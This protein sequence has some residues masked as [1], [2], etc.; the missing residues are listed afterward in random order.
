MGM[1]FIR[2]AIGTVVPREHS[3]IIHEVLNDGDEHIIAGG[4][5]VKETGTKTSTR[6][7]PRYAQQELMEQP[8]K[9]L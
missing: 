5:V 3:L 8:L 4:R 2:A 1:I 9:L 7:T 6:Q